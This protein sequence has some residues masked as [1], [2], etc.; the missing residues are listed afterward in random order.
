MTNSQIPQGR[1]GD[2]AQKPNDSDTARNAPKRLDGRR[3]LHVMSA[4]IG[5]AV[6]AACGGGAPATPS[7]G[8]TSAPAAAAPTA[9]PAA[10]ATAAPAAAASGGNTLVYGLGFDLDDTMDP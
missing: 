6:L 3:C 2:M 5:T 1:S 8:A 10:A 9:A 7:G 4:G